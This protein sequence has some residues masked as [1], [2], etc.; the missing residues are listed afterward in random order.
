[1]KFPGE[2]VQLFRDRGL[3]VTPQRECIFEVLLRG[4]DHPSAEAVH[5]EARQKMPMMSLKTV[6]QT[7][8]ELA[9]MGQV[10]QLDLGT[11][12]SRYDPNTDLHHH[13]ICRRCGKV[14]DLY[15]DFSSVRVPPEASQGFSVGRAE[16]VF[17]G[18]CQA[19]LATSSD[20]PSGF[21]RAPTTPN[22]DPGDL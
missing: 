9:R 3:K 1:V 12:S 10:V 11:G 13:L 2:M 14:R 18:L 4:G 21:P 15:A 19:C 20:C 7:L 17:R 5:A 8:H 6:Y 22:T 16:V